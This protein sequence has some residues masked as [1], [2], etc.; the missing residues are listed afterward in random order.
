[1]ALQPEDKGLVTQNT[2]RFCIIVVALAAVQWLGAGHPRA[3]QPPACVPPPA[4]SAFDPANPNVGQL[5]LQLRYYKCSAYDADV[6]AKLAEAR[7]WIDQ[8]A[9]QVAKPALVL[10]I[11]ETSLS[12]WAQMSRN[13]FGFIPS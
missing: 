10:D 5:K 3:Q 1:M 9:G 4:G 13:D 6:A 2:M 11:D 7:Q 8:R 12:N